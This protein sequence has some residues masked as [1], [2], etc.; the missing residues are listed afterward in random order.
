M[1]FVWLGIVMGGW[2]P[3]YGE[4]PFSYGPPE[5][6]HLDDIIGPDGSVLTQEKPSEWLDLLGEKFPDAPER[7]FSKFNLATE[8]P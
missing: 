7:L 4:N 3:L 5:E 1:E 2:R 8:G 6:I